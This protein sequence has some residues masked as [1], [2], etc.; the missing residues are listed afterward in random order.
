MWEEIL[1][2]YK[3]MESGDTALRGLSKD[4]WR[5]IWD[6][7]EKAETVLEEDLNLNRT[8]KASTAWEEICRIYRD[9]EVR[10]KDFCVQNRDFWKKLTNHL[11][12]VKGLFQKERR[13]LK[14]ALGRLEKEK[15]LWKEELDRWET[16]FCGSSRAAFAGRR[17]QGKGQDKAVKAQQ[18][19][20]QNH[21]EKVSTL[22]EEIWEIYESLEARN[23]DFWAQNTDLWKRMTD[24]LEKFRSIIL[25]EDSKGKVATLWF[26]IWEIYQ[27]MEA[28]NKDLWARNIDFCRTIMNL[29]EKFKKI[30][31]EE[32]PNQ[33]HK[34]KLSTLWEGMCKIY[35]N[36][37]AGKMDLL[38]RTIDFCKNDIKARKELNQ[39]Q[40]E[41]LSTL[42]KENLEIYKNMEVRK[43][44]FW[45]Q[46]IGL[47]R[48]IMDLLEKVEKTFQEEQ[49]PWNNALGGLEAEKEEELDTEF[50]GTS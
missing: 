2:M 14:D 8:E 50:C 11:E 48:K 32:D 31:L 17:K 13:V 3:N 36:M 12:K 24:L 26:T 27:N 35:K 21:R 39:S 16:E 43:I 46:N 30:V 45:V 25:E 15:G 42:W 1:E 9:I 19:L 22:M 38:G 33:N 7:L 18:E 34:E 47:C 28:G 44:D 6:I 20:Y 10:N 4:L 29:L 41:K 37:E 49:S 40:K 23:T 5:K